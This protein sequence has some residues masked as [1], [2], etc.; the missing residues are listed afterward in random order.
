MTS[1][2]L[3]AAAGRALFGERWK[4]D[5]DQ[6]LRV[7]SGRSDDWSK[8]RGE[9]APGVWRDIGRLLQER[10]EQIPALMLRCELAQSG[11][12]PTLDSDRPNGSKEAG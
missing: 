3:L 6:F 9:P 5:M 7:K 11:L 8:G 4:S 1:A 10:H 2:E 12:D